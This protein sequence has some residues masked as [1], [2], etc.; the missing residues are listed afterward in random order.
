MTSPMTPFQLAGHLTEIVA[1][2]SGSSHVWRGDP[3]T[4]D[5]LLLIGS[6]LE[7]FL[8]ELLA[9]WQKERTRD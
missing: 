2:N 3:L 8:A 6:A 1:K 4:S 7:T 9:N 5:E